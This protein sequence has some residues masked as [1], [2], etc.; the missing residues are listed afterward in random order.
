MYSDT[1]KLGFWISLH[2][3]EL[4]RAFYVSFFRIQ[5]TLKSILEQLL[6][7]FMHNTNVLLLLNL[8]MPSSF[9]KMQ[10]SALKQK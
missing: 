2:C 6:Y 4:V 10:P 3:F 8:K 5:M 9:P 1:S 7:H